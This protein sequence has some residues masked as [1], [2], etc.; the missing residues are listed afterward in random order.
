[1]DALQLIAAG[2]EVIE[3]DGWTMTIQAP[4]HWDEPGDREMIIDTRVQSISALVE[5]IQGGL[6]ATVDAMLVCLHTDPKRVAA[7]KA[8]LYTWR[9]R[10]RLEIANATGTPS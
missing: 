4:D 10:A 8:N 2:W 3:S 5:T 6:D 1:M 9:E 7:A